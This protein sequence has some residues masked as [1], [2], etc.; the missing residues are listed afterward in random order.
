MDEHPDDH[1]RRIGLWDRVETANSRSAQTGGLLSGHGLDALKG[2]ITA[3]PDRV[4]GSPPWVSDSYVVDPSAREEILQRYAVRTREFD[5]YR[6]RTDGRRPEEPFNDPNVVALGVAR[7]TSAL[8]EREV[9]VLQLM[10][11]GL[12]NAEIAKQLFI[13]H[14]TSTS[15]TRNV[16]RKLTARSRAHAVSIA[17]RAGLIA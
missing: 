8:S 10:A 5:A 3:S 13:S 14:N 15:H 17:M 6:D 1:P 12:T 9:V 4:I 11:D 2:R 16:I 7:E